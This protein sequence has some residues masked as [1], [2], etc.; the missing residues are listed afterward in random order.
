MS[1]VQFETVMMVLFVL[2]VA[3]VCVCRGLC[4]VLQD[5][6]VFQRVR[7]AQTPPS[8]KDM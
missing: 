1:R 4:V 3:V 6:C 5:R 2:Q 7:G 8:V